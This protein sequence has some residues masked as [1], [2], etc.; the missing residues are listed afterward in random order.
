[1]RGWTTDEYDVLFEHHPPTQP[2]AP[3]REE[4]EALGRRLGRS[5]LAIYAQWSDA[6]SHVLR[7]ANASSRQLRRYIDARGWSQR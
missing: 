3:T 1:M 4:C 2:T 7:H 5:R 6:R